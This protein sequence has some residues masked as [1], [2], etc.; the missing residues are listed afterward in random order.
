MKRKAPIT[1]CL[2]LD[3]V[4]LFERENPLQAAVCT[5]FL[6]AFYLGKS[7]LVVDSEVLINP[8]I[9]LRSDLYF[10]GSF[11]YVTV[12]T[13]RTSQFQKRILSLP[14][15]HVPGSLLCLMSALLNHLSINHVLSGTP[16]FSVWSKGHMCPVTYGHFS[17]FL[18]KVLKSVGLDSTNYLR[19]SLHRGSATF[20]F[21][22]S[23]LS[24]LIKVQ[25]N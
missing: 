20:A 23:V 21:E 18:T 5:L 8:K 7:N 22:L 16:L 9:L 12:H 11:A 25:G 19:H 10:D 6:V 24:E 3:I 13:S 14:L 15:P 17:S 1:Q 4:P 2:L